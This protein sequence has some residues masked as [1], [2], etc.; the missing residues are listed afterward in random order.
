MIYALSTCPWCKKAKRYFADK[1]IPYDFM[2][3]DL[4]S[5]EER[6]RVRKEF[7]KLDLD[8]SFPKVFIGE[9]VISGYRPDEYDKVLSEK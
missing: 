8:L 7:D 6:A 1:S 9:K 3:Y 2:D 5:E 4:A